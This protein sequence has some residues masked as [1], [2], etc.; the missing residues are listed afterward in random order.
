MKDFK[1]RHRQY[2]ISNVLGKEF[3]DE[4]FFKILKH[5]KKTITNPDFKE[6]IDTKYSNYIWHGL[7]LDDIY[8]RQNLKTNTFW[9]D[10]DKI[11]TFFESDFV[12]NYNEIK[13]LTE[14]VLRTHY[15][16]KEVTTRNNF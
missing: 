9:L 14:G 2:K 1:T 11:W 4:E 6:F 10:Y 5:I 3:F 12:Y 13:E 15:N 8:M 16:L 7:S